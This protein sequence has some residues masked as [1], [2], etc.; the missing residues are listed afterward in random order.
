MCLLVV[1]TFDLHSLETNNLVSEAYLVVVYIWITFGLRVPKIFAVLNSFFQSGNGVW[2]IGT[3]SSVV[4]CW[5]FQ[6]I[7][8]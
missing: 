7:S 1:M 2:V 6:E 5:Y 4:W 8:L 3:Y